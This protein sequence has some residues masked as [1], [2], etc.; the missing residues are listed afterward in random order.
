MLPAKRAGERSNDHGRADVARDNPSTLFDAGSE[1]R[2][3]MRQY[4]AYH[5]WV[6]GL[7]C[8]SYYQTGRDAF[9][10]LGIGADALPLYHHTGRL[11]EAEID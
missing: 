1:S 6:R 3:Q 11:S 10:L 9:S 8:R 4:H 7:E 5:G 2:F